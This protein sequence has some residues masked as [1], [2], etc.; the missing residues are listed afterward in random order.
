MH[1]RRPRRRR[2]G[3][4]QVRDRRRDPRPRA[5]VGGVGIR[6]PR[7]RRDDAAGPW[8]G[9]RRAAGVHQR[10]LG[11]RHR[12]SHARIARAT[13]GRLDRPRRPTSPPDAAAQAF[14]GR[15]RTCAAG[16]Q[17]ETCSPPGARRD[18]HA[19][20]AL[21]EGHRVDRGANVVD[22]LQ[23]HR[24]WKAGNAGRRAGTG[25]RS[26]SAWTARDC[27]RA[28]TASCGA[29]GTAGALADLVDAVSDGV[30]AESVHQLVQ[31]N[32][33]RSGGTID[34]IVGRRVGTARARGRAHAAYGVHGDAPDRRPLRRGRRAAGSMA[35]GSA[36]AAG[37]RRARVE[38]LGGAAPAE[39]GKPFGPRRRSS[40]PTEP[41]ARRSSSASTRS[42]SRRSTFSTS[43]RAPPSR[44]NPSSSNDSSSSREP[45]ARLPPRAA[46][47]CGCPSSAKRRGRPRT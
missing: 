28:G 1:R 25:R 43:R 19:A 45:S 9:D 14:A 42:S 34:A 10:R 4:Q 13:A 2:C 40:P 12:R 35:D 37:A 47:T 18:G 31:G 26:R 36:L 29:R 5:I 32:P 22:G 15:F 38:H 20:R 27:R 17:A 44:R 46:P 6:P 8:R 30:V 41:P 16:G 3:P 7:A 23:L 33:V 39:A 11:C 21:A 24:R